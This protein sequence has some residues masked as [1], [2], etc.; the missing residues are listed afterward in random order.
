MPTTA[1]EIMDRN[2]L[3]ASQGDSLVKLLHEMEHRGLGS[4]PVLDIDGRPV[5]VATISDIESCHDIEE[6]ADHLTRS[7]VSLP[8]NTPLL[9]A[10]R[11]LAARQAESL[12]LV[13]DAGVAVGALS[14]LDVLCAL[15][16]VQGA[17]GEHG[18]SGLAKRDAAWSRAELLELSAA[19]RAPEAPGV[20]L[21]SPGRSMG[22]TR[23]LWAES[24]VNIRERLDQMLRTPQ[25]DPALEAM[26]DVYPRDL[27]F[28]CLVVHDA[29]RRER[30]AR[31]LRTRARA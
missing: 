21:L 19:H 26:L 6:L 10:A 22:K 27:R 23:A 29:E 13:N 16:G 28:R 12:L 4:A 30:L 1:A 9:T 8:Q 7:V 15:V 18:S 14:A 20:I 11:M 24:S 17:R 31:G 2:F 5:G 25:D 3:Y